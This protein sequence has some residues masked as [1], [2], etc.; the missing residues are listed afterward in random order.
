MGAG[1]SDLGLLTLKAAECLKKADVVCY[2]SLIDLSILTLTSPECEKVHVGKRARK[3]TMPQEEINALL[4]KK[5][6]EGKTVVRLKGGD[7]FLFGR[8]AE[9]A[10]AA[11][12][13]H[14]PFEIVPGVTS[15]LAAPAYAGI[16]VTHRDCAASAAFATGHRR[17]DKEVSQINWKALSY[18][19]DTL[20]VLMG[21]SNLRRIVNKLTRGGGKHMQ[22][23]TPAAV[24]SNAG[25]P[26]QRTITA[27]LGKI[28]DAATRA[29]I[30]PPAVL[31]VGE[32]VKYREKLN[33]FESR[34]LFGRKI[35]VTRPRHQA[36]ILADRLGE[37]GAQVI[38]LPTIEIKPLSN[39][40]RTDGAIKKLLK[41]GRKAQY[42]WLIFT[43]A[44]GV[45][46]FFE[47]LHLLGGDSRSL[48]GIKIATIGPGTAKALEEYGIRA[49]L[50]PENFIAESLLK[51]LEEKVSSKRILI[52]R[53]RHARSTLPRGLKELGAKVDVISIYRTVPVECKRELMQILSDGVDIVTFTSSSTVRN[54]AKS[55]G[56]FDRKPALKLRKIKVASIGPVT[57][58]TVRKLGLNVEIE[59]TEYTIAG[60]IQA[61]LEYFSRKAEQ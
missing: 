22:H 52:P 34:P 23:K 29:S 26:R 37:L 15:A 7:P 56:I 32:V 35:L 27:P 48:G 14:I 21:V 30:K 3:H 10:L 39:Y 55:A 51:A 38:I 43:S 40:S 44:N 18:A 28:A 58:K 11:S 57:S 42:D 47:R 36:G 9:E 59:A 2:D 20:V 6:K 46:Y 16:P 33:W 41:A 53:A 5:A 61:I 49:D 8:G 24:I 60:L 25:T 17:S 13:N 12:E 54:F 31:V 19:A 45:S 4:V 50:V 1:P